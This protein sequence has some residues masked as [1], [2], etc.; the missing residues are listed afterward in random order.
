[1]TI[2]RQE[3]RIN[4]KTIGVLGGMGPAATANFY[5]RLVELS[6][7]KYGAKED[8][9]FPSI[10]LY[11]LSL[12]QLTEEGV[13]NE[14]MESIRKK[15][16]SGVKTL[17]NAGSDFIT[18][19]CNTVHYF[20]NFMR[21]QVEIPVLSIIEETV[22]RVKSDRCEKV[23][24]L[25][26]KSTL[27]W[28]LYANA[29]KAQGIELMEPNENEQKATSKIIYRVQEGSNGLWSKKILL[30]IAENFAD[31]GAEGIILGCTEL[32]LAANSKDI[33]IRIF[34][35]AAILAEAALEHAMPVRNYALV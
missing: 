19:P 13:L 1:M 7:D 9:D 24:I 22:D 6:Q 17:E 8:S 16:I 2:S 26:T 10:I 14:H 30:N 29:L 28:K 32:S 35:T 20:L 34:D 31:R 4:K 23:G 27:K 18:V 15:L 25:G 5:L 12:D 21:E 11:S 33:D 3:K